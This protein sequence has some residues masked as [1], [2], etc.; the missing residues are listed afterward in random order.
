[1]AQIREDKDLE[2][3]NSRNEE[4]RTDKEDTTFTGLNN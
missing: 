3:E 1:M 4:E 2:Q